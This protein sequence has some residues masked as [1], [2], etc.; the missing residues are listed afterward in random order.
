MSRALRQFLRAADA[1]RAA[2]VRRQ[3]E[4]FLTALFDAADDTVLR[5]SVFGMRG[6]ILV[7]RSSLTPESEVLSRMAATAAEVLDSLND[8]NPDRA[9]ETA[10]TATLLTGFAIIGETAPP[11][12]NAYLSPSRQRMPEE[13]TATA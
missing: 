4:A 2:D 11:A 13:M 9:E 1:C 7:H 6:Q 8:G 3:D 5:Q 10:R 12:V